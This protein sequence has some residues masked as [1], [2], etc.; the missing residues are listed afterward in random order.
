M[1]VDAAFA[2]RLASKRSEKNH[3]FGQAWEQRDDA[4]IQG[5]NA[6]INVDNPLPKSISS[7]NEEDRRL[8]RGI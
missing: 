6:D 1:F 3:R 8:F 5:F 4:H 7:P 2:A